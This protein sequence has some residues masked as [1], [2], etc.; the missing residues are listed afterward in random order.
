MW[1]SGSAFPPSSHFQSDF[2][3]TKT[4][5]ECRE[6][7]PVPQLHYYKMVENGKAPSEESFEFIETPPAPVSEAAVEDCGVRVTS[8]S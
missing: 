1:H 7:F 3:S 8:V 2:L 5:K 4:Q 6:V